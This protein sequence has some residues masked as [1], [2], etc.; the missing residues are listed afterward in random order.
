MLYQMPIISASAFMRQH[1]V[2]YKGFI[3]ILFY[4]NKCTIQFTLQYSTKT[5]FI[6]T[7]PATF[8]E[9]KYFLFSVSDVKLYIVQN[10]LQSQV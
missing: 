2:N 6:L 3:T 10:P 5:S 8:M 1:V 7:C 9:R 4:R